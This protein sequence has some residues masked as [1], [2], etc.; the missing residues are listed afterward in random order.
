[1]LQ[2]A[3]A[4]GRRSDYE[5]AIRDGVSDGREF[6][7][8]L[9]QSCGPYGGPSIAKGN[10][11][12][13]D[14]SQITRTEVSHGARHR[15]NIQRIAGAHEDYN[16]LVEFRQEQQAFNFTTTRILANGAEK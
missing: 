10:V 1:M 13:I 4:D 14:H 8:I 12:G 11:V 7:G 5:G 9:E 2:T 6:L 3:R 15:A 16:Q